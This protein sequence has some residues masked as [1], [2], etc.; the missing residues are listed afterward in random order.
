MNS[1]DLSII[2]ISYNTRHMTLECLR[3]IYAETS[4]LSFEVIVVDNN[5]KDDSATAIV[6]EFPQV[7]LYALKE[8][9]GFAGANN[10]AAKYA[11]GKYLL[12]LNPDTVILHRAIEKLFNFAKQYPQAGI[13]GGRTVFP[14]SSVNATCCYGK[15]TPW[16]LLCRAFGLTFLFRNS[17][18]FN[19]ETFGAWDYNTARQVDI[20]TGCFLLIKHELWQQIGGFNPLFFMYGEEVDLCLRAKK[21]GA[22]PMF[23][24]KA[25]IVHYGGASEQSQ[26]DRSLKVF[27]AK[28]ALIRM[29]WRE[30]NVRFGL[31][32]LLVWVATRAAIFNLLCSIV[33][34]KFG[35]Q[36][37]H[38]LRL[39]RKR[40]EW[41]LGFGEKSSGLGYPV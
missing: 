2:I 16:S 11:C 21:V 17:K 33:G 10:Y 34:K 41:Q 1:L 29:H 39:W 18:L 15:M 30:R 37:G 12:L 20:V 13:W 26:G 14:D 8:N 6:Y 38:W 24:P 40:R 7:N 32:M 28:S 22:Q 19:S 23:T 5:S 27:K 35:S 3:S 25:E 36:K 31:T 4:E 9:L